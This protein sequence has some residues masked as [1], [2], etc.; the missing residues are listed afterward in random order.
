LDIDALSAAL[1][2][3]AAPMHDIT[4]RYSTVAEL[5]DAP[6][7]DELL[8]EYAREASIDGLPT[9]N[10]Q[11]AT[12]QQL[13]D[14]KAL[15]V[16]GAFDGERYVGFA[17]VL[18]TVSPHFGCMLSTT[19]SLFVAKSYRHTGA[20]TKLLKAAER[21]AQASGSVGLL[22]SAPHG[23][24]LAELLPMKGYAESNRVF[25]KGLLDA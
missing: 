21:H 22:V 14:L 23:G 4:I 13:E 7:R 16:I 3:R 9:Q 6:N 5:G 11:R 20:G 2:V 8:D 12:Y 10:P 19:E 18:T 15:S 1:T 25:Y 24:R 17:L